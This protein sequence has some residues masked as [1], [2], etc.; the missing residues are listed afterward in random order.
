MSE[1]I[2]NPHH[3]GFMRLALEQAELAA[4]KGEVPVG[5]V[6]VKEGMVIAAGHNHSISLNDPSAHAEIQAL[7]R[8]ASKLGNYRLVDCDLYVTLEPC[9]MCSGAIMQA[10]LKNVF[11]G[12]SDEKIGTAGSVLNLFEIP[13]LNHQTT[14]HAGLL[15]EECAKLLKD[16]FK[17]RRLDKKPSGKNSN[18]NL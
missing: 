2:T 18:Q 1:F 15:K 4:S 13:V 9:A 10:R 6:L 12:A 3:T 17:A 14:L 11:Y 16:F 8:G 7:R 5:A